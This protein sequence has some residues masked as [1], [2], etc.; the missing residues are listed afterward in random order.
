MR[1]NLQIIM[2]TSNPDDWRILRKRFKPW[3]GVTFVSRQASSQF[4]NGTAFANIYNDYQNNLFIKSRAKF[5]NTRQST[6]KFLY[7]L[8][9]IIFRNGITRVTLHTMI[10]RIYADSRVPARHIRY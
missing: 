5:F 10:D 2:E 7:L 9:D 6:V 4:L 3:N 1:F 8:L